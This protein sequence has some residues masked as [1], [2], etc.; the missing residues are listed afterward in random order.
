MV[1]GPGPAEEGGEEI[2]G[3]GRKQEKKGIREGQEW[4]EWCKAKICYV[5]M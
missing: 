2:I 5:S 3:K 4:K 1:V